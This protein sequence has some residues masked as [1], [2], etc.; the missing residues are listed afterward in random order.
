MNFYDT[1]SC[2]TFKLI[3]SFK[4]TG[5]ARYLLIQAEISELSMFGV[6]DIKTDSYK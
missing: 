6:F 2:T 1:L 5:Y 3:G 4:L